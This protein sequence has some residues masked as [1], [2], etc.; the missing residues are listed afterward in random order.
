MKYRVKSTGIKSTETA[1]CVTLMYLF[2]TRRAFMSRSFIFRRTDFFDVFLQ[3]CVCPLAC[4]GL[5]RRGDGPVGSQSRASRNV[6][7][8]HHTFTP[9]LLCLEIN[10]AVPVDC[11]S[12]N[13]A[14]YAVFCFTSGLM[15]RLTII[16]RVALLLI[17]AASQ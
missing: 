12:P 11:I 8:I 3:R 4:I 5:S 9:L 16:V 7:R 10:R 13:W 2:D 6:S 17:L 15:R 1:Y 14:M